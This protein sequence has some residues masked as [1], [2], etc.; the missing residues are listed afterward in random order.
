MKYFFALVQKIATLEGRHK[1]SRL[2]FSYFAALFAYWKCFMSSLRGTPLH[3][4]LNL[5]L[6]WLHMS[7]QGAPSLPPERIPYG[8]HARQYFLFFKPHPQVRQRAETVVY[9]HGGGWLFGSPEAFTPHARV[10]LDAGFPAIFPSFRRIPFHNFNDMRE[11]LNR[12]LTRLHRLW[13]E[14]GWTGRRLIA[15]GMSSGGHLAA[16]LALDG[17]ALQ[18]CGWQAADIAGLFCCGAPL[19]LDCMPL[20]A[21][22]RAMAGPR[23]SEQYRKANPVLLIRNRKSPLPPTLLIHGTHDGLVPI[24][25]A[26]SFAGQTANLPD[27]RLHFHL[28]PNGSHLDAASWGHTENV[29]RRE[30][31]GWMCLIP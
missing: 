11:D 25:S 1:E 31:L 23:D 28:I 6:F 10:F 8:P 15:G 13:K 14:E 5:P 30:I 9:L 21:V 19:D 29:V 7:R 24:E 12:L 18:Q 26:R 20:T 2:P 4:L 27:V 22:V 17:S 3:E 16:H